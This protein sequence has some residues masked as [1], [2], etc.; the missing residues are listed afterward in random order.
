[1]RSWIILLVLTGLLLGGCKRDED[2]KSDNTSGNAAAPTIVTSTFLPSGQVGVAYLQ[3]I[4]ATGGSGSY[5]WTLSGGGL[6]PG[7]SLFSGTQSASISGTPSTAGSFS[8]TLTVTDSAG[9]SDFRTFG[10]DIAPAA[11]AITTTVLQ[12][13]FVGQPYTRSVAT[14]GGGGTFVWSIASGSLP[15][16]LSLLA[17]TPDAQIDG[18]PTV[19]GN[20]NFTLQ[21]TDTFGGADS[22]AFSLTIAAPPPLA[23]VTAAMPSAILGQGYAELITAAGGSQTGYTWSLILGT[24]PAGVSLAANGT[25]STV[26]SGTP[27]LSGDFD[28]TV[29]VQDSVG[30]VAARAF[31]IHVG[32]SLSITTN[33]LPV[34]TRT[35]SY[36]AGITAQGGLGFYAWSIVSGSLPPGLSLSPT[37]TPLGSVLGT[38]TA[39]GTYAFTVRV[40]SGSVMSEKPLSLTVNDPIQVLT[41]ALTDGLT[42]NAYSYPILANGGTGAGYT[43]TQVSGTLPPG[44]VL[45]ATGT[46]ATALSGT[47]TKAGSY[48][49]EV[50]VTDSA[51]AQAVGQITVSIYPVIRTFAGDGTPAFGGDTGLAT[52]AQLYWPQGM[53]FTSAGEMVFAD[54]GNGRIRKITQAG[55]ITT[56]AGV[57]SAGF[58]GDGG[59]ALSAEFDNPRSV[60]VDAQDNIYVADSYNHRVRRIDA[61]TAIIT[62]IAGSGAFGY[63]GGSFAGDN[64]LAT[65]ARLNEPSGLAFDSSGNLYIADSNNHRVRMVDASTSNISTV[66]GS[67]TAGPGFGGYSGDGGQ[68]TSAVFKY[69]FALAFDSLGQML[70]ADYG[71]NM[72]RRVDSAGIVTRIAGQWMAGLSGDGGQATNCQMRSP[73]SLALDAAGNLYIADFG[74]HRVRRVDATSGVITTLAGGSGVLGDGG[75]ASSA[76]LSDPMEVV[77]NAAGDLFIADRAHQR[78]RI[79][80]GP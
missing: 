45:A 68:A 29:R 33:S 78:I 60:V 37:G 22:Q 24:L 8:F 1:M 39:T 79:V 47:P 77:F 51:M 62:T 7:L 18:T 52:A 59:A 27:T 38:P 74:N 73:S 80:K 15:P 21:V 31:N 75:P 3:S 5:N 35:V 2:G 76:S 44:L 43:W 57:G 50:R 11:L 64:G 67:G 70:I 54:S 69:P 40:T 49:F 13:G 28:F 25:P 20:F 23:V 10:V 34:A 71:N 6:P 72:V 19:A 36:A 30:H 66:A 12:D 26:L 17:A 63:A 46:P 56:I 14:S 32:A 16:G 58:S 61:L 9:Y 65:S 42:D 48:Q 55:I 53:A 41:G 4:A